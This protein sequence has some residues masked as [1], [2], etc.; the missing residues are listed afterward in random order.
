M[1][2]PGTPA[3]TYFYIDKDDPLPALSDQ[4]IMVFDNDGD[5]SRVITDVVSGSPDL[6]QI[7]QLL[8]TEDVVLPIMF[9]EAGPCV[10]LPPQVTEKKV[11]LSM[12]GEVFTIII[13]VVVDKQSFTTRPRFEESTPVELMRIRNQLDYLLD[14][15]VFRNLIKASRIGYS[16]SSIVMDCCIHETEPL[17]GLHSTIDAIDL[18]FDIELHKQVIRS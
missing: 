18:M 5:D 16:R 9:L 12:R 11:E 7:H 2:K 14:P 6:M 4:E 1:L 3:H 17:E 8:E 10:P 15:S 13:R